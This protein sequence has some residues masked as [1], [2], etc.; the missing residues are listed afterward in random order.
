[1]SEDTIA[2]PNPVPESAPGI[3]VGPMATAQDQAAP[4]VDQ[5]TLPAAEDRPDKFPPL[6]HFV[7]VRTYIDN[8]GIRIDHRVT[9]HG[10]PPRGKFHEYHAYTKVVFPGTGEGIPIDVAVRGA[11][12]IL[13]AFMAAPDLLLQAKDALESRVRRHQNRGANQAARY[14]RRPRPP[15]ARAGWRHHPRRRRRRLRCTCRP[16]GCA[17]CWRPTRAW[18]RRTAMAWARRWTTGARSASR[19]GRPSRICT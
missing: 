13:E 17:R 1:M 4:P 8:R 15:A 7:E 12:T 10:V 14:R 19:A 9:A 2:G 11:T 16:T 5:I 6:E 3:P 18:G